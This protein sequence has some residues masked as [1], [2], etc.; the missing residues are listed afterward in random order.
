MAHKHVQLH[1]EQPADHGVLLRECDL[2][3]RDR[4]E[5][6]RLCV[7]CGDAIARLARIAANQAQPVR[8]GVGAS[9]GNETLARMVHVR[10][11]ESRA[12]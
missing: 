12:A 2:C 10:E 3:R 8:V 7:V 4:A 5:G 9:G 11:E 6:S 1:D